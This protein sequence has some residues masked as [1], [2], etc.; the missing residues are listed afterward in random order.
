MTATAVQ[1]DSIWLT[2]AGYDVAPLNS[3]L[4][5]HVPELEKA[6]HA[7]LPAYPDNHRRNFYDVELESGWA[8]IHVRSDIETVYLVAYSSE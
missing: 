1:H 5:G 4:A 3:R 6:L 2:A 8:Y 7:G